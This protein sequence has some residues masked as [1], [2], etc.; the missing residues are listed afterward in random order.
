M[1]TLAIP[2]RLIQII[3]AHAQQNIEHQQGGVIITK[4]NGEMRFQA[5]LN[6]SDTPESSYKP[7][8]EQLATLEPSSISAV[9]YSQPTGSG[10]AQ[11]LPEFKQ[12]WVVSLNTKGVLELYVWDTSSQPP[13]AVPQYLTVS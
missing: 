12:H 7:R 2:R 4:A 13:C 10:A 8:A 3:Y 5:L 1:Q 6:G 9:V 11:I